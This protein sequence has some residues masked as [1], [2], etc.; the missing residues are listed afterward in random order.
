MYNLRI[1]SIPSVQK[2]GY[3]DNVPFRNSCNLEEGNVRV[4][5]HQCQLDT[6]SFFGEKE[7]LINISYIIDSSLKFIIPISAQSTSHANLSFKFREIAICTLCMSPHLVL[8]AS[9][10]LPLLFCLFLIFCLTELVELKLNLRYSIKD[11][12]DISADVAYIGGV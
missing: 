3:I 5:M 2:K 11:A 10:A 1:T 12:E 6:S 9:I 8:K 7:R 4:F